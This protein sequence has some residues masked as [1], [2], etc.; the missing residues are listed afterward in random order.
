MI[1]VKIKL[2]MFEMEA[3]VL[4]ILNKFKDLEA[5]GRKCEFGWMT[6]YPEDFKKGSEL[7]GFCHLCCRGL[8][9]PGYP[10]CEFRLSRELVNRLRESG[11]IP[12][13]TID[14]PTS[15]ERIGRMMASLEGINELSILP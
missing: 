2:G 8:I 3:A 15:E 10:N 5:K 7:V 6:L 11:D 9:E 13:D 1:E 14:P 12:S 4:V